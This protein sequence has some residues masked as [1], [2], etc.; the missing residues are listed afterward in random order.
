LAELLGQR[1]QRL[2]R[3]RAGEAQGHLPGPI[4]PGVEFPQGLLKCLTLQRQAVAIAGM[5][6]SQGMV[7]CQTFQQCDLLLRVGVFRPGNKLRLQ[8]FAFTPLVFKRQARMGEHIGQ[9]FQA[10]RKGR[11]RQLKEEVRGA[12]AGAGVDLPAMALHVGHQ[13]F[14]CR[15]PLGA[16]K[17]QMLKKMRQPWPGQWHVM[18]AGGHA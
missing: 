9:P 15:K 6:A 7:G 18:A 8:H 16:E 4:E 11:Y 17:Q 14:V 10:P 5:K 1:V 2:Q 13:P 3:L 12:F